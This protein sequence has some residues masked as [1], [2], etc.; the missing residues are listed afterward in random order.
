MPIL[1]GSL[2]KAGIRFGGNTFFKGKLQEQKAAGKL[3]LPAPIVNLLGGVCAG[4]CE[5]VLAVTPMETVKTKT[6]QMNCGFVEGMKRIVADEGMGGLY[7]GVAPTVVKQASNQGLRFMF[8]GSYR[9]W[10][11]NGNPDTKLSP[12]QSLA[13]GMGAGCFSVLGNNPFDVVKTKLQGTDAAKFNGTIDC[14]VKTI[15][16][17]GIGGMYAGVLPRLYRVVPGQGII[18]MSVDLIEPSVKKGLGL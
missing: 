9:E 2:P 12:L 14:F 6:I 13:G 7:T 1:L 17:E 16:N 11:T 3:P 10:M 18:F 4:A 15:K 5:A 8:M